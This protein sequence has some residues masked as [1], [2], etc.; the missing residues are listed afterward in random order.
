MNISGL[1]EFTLSVKLRSRNWLHDLL[2]ICAMRFIIVPFPTW[3]LKESL[4]PPA[5]IQIVNDS[6]ST[7]NLPDS[8]KDAFEVHQC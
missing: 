3:H 1:S 6:L 4:L 8:L 2:P 5:L 7:G